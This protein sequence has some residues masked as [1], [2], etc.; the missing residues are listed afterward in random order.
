MSM[1]YCL[2]DYNWLP[3]ELLSEGS[4]TYKVRL[5]GTFGNLYEQRVAKEKCAFPDEVVCVVWETW[6]GRNGRGGYRVER[7]LYPQ[8]R[9]PADKVHFQDGGQA[10]NGRVTESSLGFSFLNT[11]LSHRRL[12]IHP[13]P[14]R[15]ML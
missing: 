2:L 4:K 8:E 10:N 1:I 13:V 12:Q 6:K 9:I 14:L 15:L 11:F 7:T 3:G 5:R